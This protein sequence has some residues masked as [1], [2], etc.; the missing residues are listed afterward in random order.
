MIHQSLSEAIVWQVSLVI[1]SAI[2]LSDVLKV[3][4]PETLVVTVH[5]SRCVTRSFVAFNDG[6]VS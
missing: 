1:V 2:C 3:G 5:A 4:S 6:N